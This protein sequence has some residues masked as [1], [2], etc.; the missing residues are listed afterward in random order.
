MLYWKYGDTMNML[1]IIIRKKNKEALSYDELKYA[2]NNYLSGKIPDYQ[3]SALLMAITINGMN[4]SETL[5]LT[6]IFIRSGETYD[7]SSIA[8]HVVDKHSTGGVGDSTTL[9]VGPICAAL[10]LKMAKMSGRGLGL[11]GGT[12]DKVES[13]PGFIVNE[14]KEDFFEQVRKNGFALSSQSDNLVPLD[15]VIYALRDVTGTTESIPLIASSIMSK[16][17]ALGAT[18]ILIDIKV[19]SGALLHTKEEAEILS[20]WLIDIGDAYHRKVETILSD[21][22]EPLSFAIGNALEVK[23]AINVLNGKR[24]PLFDTAVEIAARLLTM[25]EGTDEKKAQELAIQAID[26]GAA[27]TCFNDFVTAQGG[28]LSKLKVSDKVIKVKAKNDGIIESIDALGA[29]KLAAKLGATKKTLD[30]KID[31]GVGILLKVKKGDH[32]KKNDVLMELYVKNYNE[33]FHN[34]DFAFI[35]IV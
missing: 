31:Y 11:T 29:A 34:G 7:L 24:S 19:G 27:L 8:P 2:F 23:E 18:D 4:M 25:V 33:E 35:E 3:M 30:D 16:K 20:K 21:M 1:D 32:I 26:S 10:G 17:I 15:K 28:D 6:D 14:S 22:N 9:V 5:A 13:I 12:I